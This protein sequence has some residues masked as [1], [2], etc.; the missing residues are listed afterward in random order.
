M[1]I[2]SSRSVVP[3]PFHSVTAL[4]SAHDVRHL[5]PCKICQGLLD[6]RHAVPVDSGH[7][8]GR[9]Y[10]STFGMRKFHELPAKVLGE[11]TLNDIGSEAMR[12]LLDTN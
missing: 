4:K 1:A 2:R 9:C 10:I 12:A 3:L 5:A 11:M 7:V 8:H 6:D